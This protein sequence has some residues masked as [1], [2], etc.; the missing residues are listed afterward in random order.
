MSNVAGENLYDPLVVHINGLP[1]WDEVKRLDSAFERYLG[2]E[3]T[4]YVRAI[5]RKFF[6]SLI[7]RALKPGCKVDTVLVL[8]GKQGA[9]KSSWAMQPGEKDTL[10][11][12]RGLW[13]I[14][15]GELDGLSKSDIAKT[16]RFISVDVDR[17]RPSYGRCPVNVARRSVF[18]GTSNDSG[19][20]KDPTGARRFW[21]LKVGTIDNESFARDRDQILAEAKFFFEAGE[22][23]HLTDAE[24]IAEQ[25][26]ETDARRCADP[27]E[28]YISGWLSDTFGR[29]AENANE[30]KFGTKG[31]TDEEIMERVLLLQPGE[32]T[33]QAK[34]RV[35][36]VMSSLGWKWKQNREFIGNGRGRCWARPDEKK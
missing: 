11:C 19:Y 10:E 14:E 35:R 1:A 2:A 27:W 17:Y 21:P 15:L 32:M 28:A 18:I 6:V 3:G 31:V 13:V 23:W 24:A 33:Q 36:Q 29:A 30:L 22:P 9:G 4:P 12:M 7:A 16:K 34:S 8:E 25:E 5:S 20:L 26:S